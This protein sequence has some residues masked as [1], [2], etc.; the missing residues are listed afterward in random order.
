MRALL[1]DFRAQ[2]NGP[3]WDALIAMGDVY[4]RGAFPR[5][6]PDRSMAMRCYKLAAMSPDGDVAGLGQA[7]YIE[8]HEEGILA[9]DT[10]GDPLP[11]RFGEE[12]CA[13]ALQRVRAA[14]LSAFAR[15]VARRPPVRENVRPPAPARYD[16]TQG[17]VRPRLETPRVLVEIAAHRADQQN[18]HDHAVTKTLKS[19]VQA[20]KDA[21]G[22]TVE[23]IRTS[24]GGARATL[25][26]V[27]ELVRGDRELTTAEARDAKG[28]IGRLSRDAHETLGVSEVG[29]LRLVL[30]RIDAMP[31][32]RLRADLFHMLAKQLASGTEN[33]TVVCSTGRLARILGTLDGVEEAKLDAVRPM[34]AVDQEIATLAGR[35]REELL[36]RSSP[37]ER[38]AYETGQPEALATKA[39]AAMRAE[40]RRH[41]RETYVAGLGMSDAILSPLVEKY[42][43]GF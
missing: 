29:A 25:D 12:I 38:A 33:G 22:T 26:R 19:N 20:L 17:W 27:R 1:D 3:R 30:K 4:G 15:P 11:T 7:K 35:V 31:D 34:W 40:L 28:V 23:D 36:A 6:R 32:P 24:E 10:A 43:A 2:R 13:V 39:E 21:V 16:G 18:V 41:V 14:P 9:V 42:E 5:F 8:A 37:E